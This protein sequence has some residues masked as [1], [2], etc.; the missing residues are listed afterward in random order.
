[1]KKSISIALVLVLLI[2]VLAGCGD[3]AKTPGGSAPD[4]SAPSSAVP[5][6]ANGPTRALQVCCPPVVVDM[7]SEEINNEIVAFITQDTDNPDA[8]LLR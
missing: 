4:D 6:S 1:M 2:S 8:V 7:T 3:G 5:D